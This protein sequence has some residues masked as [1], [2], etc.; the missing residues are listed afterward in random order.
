MHERPAMRGAK[1][2]PLADNPV[3]ERAPAAVGTDPPQLPSRTQEREFGSEVAGG[4]VQA[5]APQ[6]RHALAN[7][8]LRWE[9]RN[10][11]TNLER[12]HRSEIGAAARQRKSAEFVG[13][14]A[15]VLLP[16]EASPYRDPHRVGR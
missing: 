2:L 5:A 9:G 3:G 7:Q 10:E 6:Q 13:G 12:A 14:G 4:F 11:D 16:I 15:T 1:G 8:K